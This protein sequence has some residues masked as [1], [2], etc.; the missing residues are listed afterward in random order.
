MAFG[1]LEISVN[2]SN[3]I[4]LF[5]FQI[6]SQF[7]RYT[8]ALS[9]Y[10]YISNTYTSITIKIT[11]IVSSQD[12]NKKSVTIIA[13]NSIQVALNGIYNKSTSINNITITELQLSDDTTNIIY[14]GRVLTYK[15]TEYEVKIPC[16]SIYSSVQRIGIQRDYGPLCP[17]QLYK[18][19]TCRAVASVYQ[20]NDA[21]D[22]VSNN[23]ISVFS[24][25]QPDDY[26]TGGFIEF[27]VPND[28]NNT[29]MIVDHTGTNLTLE[30]IHPSIIPNLSISIYPGCDRTANTCNSKFSN[31]PNHGGF[32]YHPNKNPYTGTKVF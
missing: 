5:D 28:L 7:Y 4:L 9:D 11:E 1:D 21:I 19:N 15:F 8:N 24:L 26:F 27:S 32:V 6:G 18:S 25:T 10:E 3:K 2:Q 29:L 22:D 16:E 23:V 17:H 20:V 30:Y 14:K 13:D 31:L 12:I